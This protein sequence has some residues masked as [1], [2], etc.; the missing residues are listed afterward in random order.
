MQLGHH[1]VLAELVGAVVDDAGEPGFAQVVDIVAEQMEFW[2]AIRLDALVSA[3]IFPGQPRPPLALHRHLRARLPDYDYDRHV[4]G[5]IYWFMRGA[6]CHIER[7]PRALIEAMD[8][9]VREP[10]P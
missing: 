2:F 5:A 6:A 4:G 9:V 8:R 10:A 7:P 3:Q 1:F